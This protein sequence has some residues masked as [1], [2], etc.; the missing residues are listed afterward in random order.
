MC[1]EEGARRRLCCTAGNVV[2]LLD[3]RLPYDIIILFLDF[4]RGT[5]FFGWLFALITLLD[6]NYLANLS[7]SAII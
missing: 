5:S 3:S 1:F 2:F 6:L 4:R 7:I